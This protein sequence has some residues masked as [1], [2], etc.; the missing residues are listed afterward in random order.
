[1]QHQQTPPAPPRQI[2]P[3]KRLIISPEQLR[4]RLRVSIHFF[5]NLFF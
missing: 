2:K 4:Y 5:L 1:M 3:N